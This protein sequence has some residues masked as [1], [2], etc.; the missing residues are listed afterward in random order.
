MTTECDITETEA[1][2][3][4]APHPSWSVT[5]RLNWLL[6]QL[7]MSALW[8]G[9]FWFGA[10]IFRDS[11]I[12]EVVDSLISLAQ[13]IWLYLAALA[14]WVGYNIALYRWRGAK[15]AGEQTTTVFSQDY[16][17]RRL[18][19]AE[20]A[21]LSDSHLIVKMTEGSKV[22]GHEVPE[23]APTSDPTQLRP[24]E[25]PERQEARAAAVG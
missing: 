25:A 3:R 14:L 1:T 8:L 17:G 12:D 18:E 9:F 24:A 2:S 13:A 23:P 5:E 19:V 6:T 20:G 11:P 16:F 10:K 4:T 21:T 22:Y 15:K 7:L